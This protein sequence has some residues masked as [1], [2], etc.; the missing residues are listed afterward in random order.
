MS[1]AVV[2]SAGGPS[3]ELAIAAWLDA[4]ARKSDSA[5][6]AHAYQETLAGLRATLQRA[7]LDLDSPPAAVAL[8]GQAWAYRRADGV[9]TVAPST[10]NQRLA[11]ASSFYTF[12]IR[13]GLLADASGALLAT[14]PIA[15]VERATVQRYAGAR[16]LP[17]DTV[18]DRL[19]AIDRSTLAGMRDYAVLSLALQT[20]RRSAELRALRLADLVMEPGAVTVIWRR[21]KGGRVM[22]DTL[23]PGTAAA[24]VGYLRAAYGAQLAAV[25]ADAPVFFSLARN[26]HGRSLSHQALSDIF[27]RR[28]GT[29]RVHAT[30][31]TFARNMEDAGAKVS[32]IQRRLGHASIAT[33]GRYLAELTSSD[34]PYAARLESMFG[35]A[36]A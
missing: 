1:T 11:I 21:C 6:T 20:G 35:I 10:S 5:R 30:R 33:T 7:G 24:L 12:G 26:S 29:S 13:R 25:P 14:N 4:K 18:A 36:S 34:N 15:M 31:H 32:D 9:G 17:V 19:A 27:E 3:L 22:Q 23:A 16:P 8:V 2:V 28:L